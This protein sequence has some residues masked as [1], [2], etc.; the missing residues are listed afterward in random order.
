MRFCFC[1]IQNSLFFAES[2]SILKVEGIKMVI[3]PYPD[4]IYTK[5]K[6]RILNLP[7]DAGTSSS[8]KYP[9]DGWGKLLESMP[10]FSRAEMNQHVGSSGKRVA[11]TEHHSIPTNLRKAKTFLQDEYLKEIEANSDQRYMYFYL[12]TK[13]Y[14][15][16][17]K[18][19]PPHALRFSMCMVSGQVIHENC[20]CKAGN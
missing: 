13:C 10:A 1:S 14:H 7:K 20:S 11:N 2:T 6:A 5:R 19:E 8:V 15:S 16:F 9:S 4:E 12:R 17:K 3:D 18:S